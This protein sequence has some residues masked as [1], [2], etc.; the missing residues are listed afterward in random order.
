MPRKRRGTLPGLR[1]LPAMPDGPGQ[2][3]ALLERMD[4]FETALTNAGYFPNGT[5]NGVV[6]DPGWGADI[7]EL[8]MRTL[9]H[10]VIQ[11]DGVPRT[12]SIKLETLR[13]T[14]DSNNEVVA[15]DYEEGAA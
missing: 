10:E 9:P 7:A 5:A 1:N 2:E 4:L 15:W 14:V 8:V 3:A 11:A 12:V 6:R 13:V